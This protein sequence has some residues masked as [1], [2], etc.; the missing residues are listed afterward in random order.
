MKNLLKMNECFNRIIRFEFILF[1]IYRAK[2]KY[3]TTILDY[4]A[5]EQF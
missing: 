3:M 1:I 2:I 5:S 4:S